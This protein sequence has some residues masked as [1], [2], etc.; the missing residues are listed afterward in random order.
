MSILFMC[1]TEHDTSMYMIHVGRD[2]FC[3]NLCSINIMKQNVIFLV[4]RRC[5]MY[6]S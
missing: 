5:S 3:V 6:L 1:W 2:K 4:S